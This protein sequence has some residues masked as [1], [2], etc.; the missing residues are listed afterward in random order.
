MYWNK[1]EKYFYGNQPIFKNYN[2]TLQYVYN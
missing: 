1:K 2:L